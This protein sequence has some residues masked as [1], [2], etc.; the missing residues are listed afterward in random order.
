MNLWTGDIFPLVRFIA[1]CTG[2]T[3]DAYFWSNKENTLATFGRED[4]EHVISN[5]ET[6]DYLN[7]H[8]VVISCGILGSKIAIRP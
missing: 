2:R 8:D 6:M 7:Y 1:N 3:L 5:K 4:S